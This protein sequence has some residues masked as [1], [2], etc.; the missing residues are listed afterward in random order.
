MEIKGYGDSGE[1]GRQIRQHLDLWKSRLKAAKWQTP[2]PIL[3]SK[4]NELFSFI[5]KNVQN[6]GREVLLQLYGTL[7]NHTMTTAYCHGL[8]IKV[9][10]TC[11]SGNSENIIDSCFVGLAY[12]NFSEQVPEVIV[13]KK[14]LIVNLQA[15]C[16]QL[17]LFPSKFKTDLVL[18]YSNQKEAFY[19]MHLQ[20]A[21]TSPDEVTESS[22]Q[23]LLGQVN[24][25]NQCVIQA[26]SPKG[27]C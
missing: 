2:K 24:S 17:I 15:W 11:T 8:L 6:K 10:C 3:I 23:K 19:L 16:G 1:K 22:N 20:T 14:I 4:K 18:I 12:V 27:E 13:W 21:A 7:K 5:A 26:N 9:E 25:G